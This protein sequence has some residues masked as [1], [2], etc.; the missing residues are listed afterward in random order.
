M[1]IA[2]FVVA[3]DLGFALEIG[4]LR[5]SHRSSSPL[6]LFV[7]RIVRLLHWYSERY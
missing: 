4:S 1:I 5:A 6:V 2:P 7:L 3:M